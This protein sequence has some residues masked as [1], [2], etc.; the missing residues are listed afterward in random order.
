[1]KRL[2]LTAMIGGSIAI[3]GCA[4][5]PNAGPAAA[6]DYTPLATQPHPRA[7]L[8]VD[9]IA[10]ATA[11]GAYGY[12][13]DDGNVRLLFT[14]TG[15]PARTFYEGLAARSAAIGSETQADGRTFR[16][17]EVIE[18]DLFGVDYC[19]TDGANDFRCIVSLNTGA[20]LL[21]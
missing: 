4:T 20:A 6:P 13:E 17:T 21:E 14:C 7:A 2:A 15:A 11:A 8:Y 3:T 9:C 1:M 19:S 12:A 10:Q 18:R 5:T 16:T